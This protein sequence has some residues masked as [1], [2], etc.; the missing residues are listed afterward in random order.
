MISASRKLKNS[1][2][3]RNRMPTVSALWALDWS[4]SAFGPLSRQLGPTTEFLHGDWGVGTVGEAL[5]WL[6]HEFSHH[7]LDVDERA[8]A[9]AA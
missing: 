9:S 3:C 5:V 2:V 1:I 8:G 7:E 4:V 6:G